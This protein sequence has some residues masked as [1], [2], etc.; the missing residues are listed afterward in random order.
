MKK[1]K[2]NIEQKSKEILCGQISSMERAGFGYLSEIVRAAIFQNDQY[3]EKLL[4]LFLKN[5]PD[6]IF[7]DM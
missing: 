1:L 7:D 2:A 4:P 6:V 3:K 5:N